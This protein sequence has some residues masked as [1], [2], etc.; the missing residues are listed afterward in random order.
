M[1]GV[2]L[3]EHKKASILHLYANGNGSVTI[4]KL[5]GISYKSALRVLEESGIKIRSEGGPGGKR[6]PL[7]DDMASKIV[8][9]YTKNIEYTIADVAERVGVSKNTVHKALQDR[10][11]PMRPPG[12]R[13]GRVT[14]IPAEIKKQMLSFYK[15]GMSMRQVAEKMEVTMN[16]VWQIL[17]EQGVPRRPVGRRPK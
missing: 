13:K 2:P 15:G 17:C 10:A 12:R 4:G 16:T 8:D 6:E 5:L 11:V 1:R 14:A 9:L 7:T 3:D